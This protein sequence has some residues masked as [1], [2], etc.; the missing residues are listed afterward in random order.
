MQ[1]SRRVLRVV[2]GEQIVTLTSSHQFVFMNII[3]FPRDFACV[4]LLTATSASAHEFP[5][6][7]QSRPPAPPASR[8]P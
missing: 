7:F 6:L 4:L 3:R 8:P 1:R 2:R 5:P